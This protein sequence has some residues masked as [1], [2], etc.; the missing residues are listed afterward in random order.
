MS[1]IGYGYGSEWHLLRFLG[2]HRQYLNQQVEQAVNGNLIEWLDFPFDSKAN[3]YDAEWKGLDFLT[4]DHPARKEWEKF[5]P[6]SGN[7]QNWDAVG[8]IKSSQQEE[9]LLVEAKASLQE[10]ESSCGAKEHGGLPVI[11]AAFQET[12]EAFSVPPEANWL[13]PYYQY[14]NRLSV[15]YF[16]T[17][18]N[19]PARLLFV[20]FIGDRRKNKICPKSQDEWEPAL[21]NLKTHLGLIGTSYLETSIHNLFINLGRL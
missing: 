20:Y 14:A 16:L 3:I 12:K 9:W 2:Y 17:K 4:D 1:T 13:T 7:V 11:R 21:K 18:N 6:Q 10:L 8:R 5:W 19:V 15:L